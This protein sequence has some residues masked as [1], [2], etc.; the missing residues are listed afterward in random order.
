MLVQDIKSMIR[1]RGES[2]ME[3]FEDIEEKPSSL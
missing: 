1:N 2:R 3:E